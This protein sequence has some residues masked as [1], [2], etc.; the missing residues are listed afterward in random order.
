MYTLTRGR[1]N[2]FLVTYGAREIG[3]GIARS[4][5]HVF[6]DVGGVLMKCALA[7]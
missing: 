5:A 2:F 7:F 1:R 4:V 6:L 3:A